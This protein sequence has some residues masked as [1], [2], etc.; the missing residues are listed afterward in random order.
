VRLTPKASRLFESFVESREAEYTARL[1]Q[2]F[3]SA[4][5]K[6]LTDLLG[7]IA[8]NMGGSE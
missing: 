1:L 5:T 7:R 2:G 3:T 6:T 4:E 8:D